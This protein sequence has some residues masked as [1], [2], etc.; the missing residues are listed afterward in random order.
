MADLSN[1]PGHFLRG[2]ASSTRHNALAYG[3]SLTTTGSFGVLTALDHTPHVSDV[4][5]FGIG[6]AV[7]FTLA[8]TGVTRGFRVAQEEEP[9]VV[10]AIGASFGA[11]SVSGGV[12]LAALVGWGTSGWVPWLLGPFAASSVYLMLSA[13]EFVAA[14]RI[15]EAA[16]LELGKV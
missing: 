2:L 7:T 9:R 5:L 11:V 8:T 1:A 14:R 15:S 6:G 12:G 3:Y 10:Q 4:I 16:D 13:L